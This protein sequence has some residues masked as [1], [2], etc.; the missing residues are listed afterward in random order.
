MS[1]QLCKIG[2][3]IPLTGSWWGGSSSIRS[4][5]VWLW[6]DEALISNERLLSPM[7][8]MITIYPAQSPCEH[9][10]S[11][12]VL[13]YIFSYES[14]EVLCVDQWSRQSL[15][16]H[17]YYPSH[18][19]HHTHHSIPLACT[20]STNVDGTL[21][22]NWV[23]CWVPHMYYFWSSTKLWKTCIIQHSLYL[24]PIYWS[25]TTYQALF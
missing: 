23:L 14:Q 12:S 15:K 16:H 18:Q 4:P 25:S 13:I 8:I 22:G 11:P 9:L 17:T 20:F 19:P 1:H 7:R 3:I 21:S 2:T 24:I 6:Q 5:A 10:L